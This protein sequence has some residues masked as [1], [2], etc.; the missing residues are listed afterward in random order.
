MIRRPPR[1]TPFP[2]RRAADL[3]ETYAVTAVA[4]MLLGFLRFKDSAG[5]PELGFVIY[6]LV[7]GA[8]SIVAT[9]IGS[10][11]VRLP[12]SGWIMGALYKGLGASALIALP[13]FFAVIGVGVTVILVAVTEFFTGSQFWP[14]RTIAAASTTGHATNIIAGLSIGMESTAIPVLTIG[15]GIL[16]S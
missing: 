4:A 1:S 2:T 8:I 6:P 9:V 16:L 7:L 10:N 13:V 5:N 12:R 15:V 3:F 11:F 14:V